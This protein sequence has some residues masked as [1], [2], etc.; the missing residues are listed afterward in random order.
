MSLGE[1]LMKPTT[2]LYRNLMAMDVEESIRAYPL[3]GVVL[4]TGCDK[5]TPASIMGAAS[6]DIPAIVVTGGPML[7][8]HW[9]G[10]EL[11]SCSDCWHYHEELRAGRI[12]EAEFGEI[13][14]AMSRSNGHCM[15]MGTASTMAC[16]TE[17]LGMTLPGSGG[18]SRGGLAARAAGRGGRGGGSSSWSRQTCGRP[19]SSPRAAFENAIRALHAIR[20][21]TN[22]ILH[23]LAFA[24]RVGVDLPLDA[25]RR[26][27]RVDAVARRP[28]P[29]GTHPDGGL[30]LRGRAAGGAGADRAVCCT[31][32]R[33]P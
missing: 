20:G 29:A 27:R 13:E 19:T 8:G 28:K 18:D 14:N 30:L 2:M 31:A 9:R 3:D 6:A 25:V 16:L 4:L 17:A 33:S 24:G 1:S 26:A 21:S 32:R 15:T 11:G 10:N 23:L 7:N 5:T 12:S 22:A